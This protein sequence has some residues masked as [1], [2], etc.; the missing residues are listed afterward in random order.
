MLVL[1]VSLVVCVMMLTKGCNKLP[2]HTADTHFV[3][4]ITNKAKRDSVNGVLYLD[5]VNKVTAALR[6]QNDSLEH[7]K[8]HSESAVNQAKNSI[9]KLVSTI[10]SLKA[11]NDTIGELQGCDDLRQMLVNDSA[12]LVGYEYLSDSLID[13]LKQERLLSDTVKT[14]IFNMFSDANNGL[15]DISRKYGLLDADYKK[16]VKMATKRIGIGPELTATLNNGKVVVLPG[17]GLHYSL[18]KF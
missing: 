12:L 18:F 17:V 9:V 4:S 5:S 10:D 11:A 8:N 14:H 1:F 2:D 6:K 3:D 13:K 15:F 7:L 16:A